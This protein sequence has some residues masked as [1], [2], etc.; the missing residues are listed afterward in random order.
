[1]FHQCN[2]CRK[3]SFEL[4]AGINAAVG[5]ELLDTHDTHKSAAE[6][7]G[8]KPFDSKANRLQTLADLSP[9]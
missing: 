6:P 8:P 5:G 9:N 4:R 3:T 7:D 2:G 1:M